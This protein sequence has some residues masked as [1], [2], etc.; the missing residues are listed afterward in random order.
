MGRQ[1]AGGGG[2]GKP[3]RV[4]RARSA[5]GTPC[6]GR[7]TTMSSPQV[8]CGAQGPKV[9]RLLP[10]PV[11]GEVL[12]GEEG[13]VL[14]VAEGAGARKGTRKGSQMRGLPSVHASVACSSL[15]LLFPSLAHFALTC[16]PPPR[17]SCC[18]ARRRG[19]PRGPQGR[20]PWGRSAKASRL[21]RDWPASPSARGEGRRAGQRRRK[22][23]R[24]T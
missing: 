19:S 5:Q 15:P 12:C 20:P 3:C 16:T 22:E 13:V 21:E 17:T 6:S 23:S 11:G 14:L 9:V 4:G 10:R 2:R 18:T 1:R 24:S 7:R 8:E